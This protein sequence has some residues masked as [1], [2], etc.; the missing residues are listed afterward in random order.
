MIRWCISLG[1]VEEFEETL[2][3][4][5]YNDEMLHRFTLR[6]LLKCGRIDQLQ[7]LALKFKMQ[8]DREFS[9][10]MRSR[11]EEKNPEADSDCFSV[12]PSNVHFVNDAISFARFLV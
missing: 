1:K 12:D 8:E 5:S 9:K 6:Q 2:C 10:F 11:K 7:R 3:F 4:G